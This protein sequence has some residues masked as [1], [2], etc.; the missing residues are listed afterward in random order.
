MCNLS[1][2]IYDKSNK[3]LIFDLGK[4]FPI[5][6]TAHPQMLNPGS[7]ICENFA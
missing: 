2:A 1:Q 6:F 4:S 5:L 7:I 3:R